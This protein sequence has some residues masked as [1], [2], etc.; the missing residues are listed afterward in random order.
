MGLKIALVIGQAIGLKCLQTISEKKG[1]DIKYVVS[2]DKRYYAAIKKI[3]KEKKI[4]FFK[5]LDENILKRKKLNDIFL[6]SIFSTI[7]LKKS[8]LSKFQDCFNIHP[9]ILPEYP[10]VNP[11]SGM[12]FNCEKKIGVTI[13]KMTQKVDAGEIVLI[14]KTPINFKDNLLSCTKKIEFLTKNILLKFINKLL[15]KKK[16]KTFR[17][18]TNKKKFFPKKIPNSGFLN[19]DWKFNEFL[20]YF[21][22]GFS[23]P[24]QSE[25]GRVCFN[26]NGKKIIIYDFKIIKI[27]NKKKILKINE[28]TYDL[29]LKDKTI[30]VS[31]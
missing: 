8:V 3:C 5:R 15:S 31:T 23:G 4:V 20:K 10:G 29:K 30:R 14:N 26:Y 2:I 9:A 17:N 12:I 27:I 16:I 28:N 19:L 7:I 13:H 6:L 22:A 24:Y 21:N 11:I 18:N 1:V 25:W